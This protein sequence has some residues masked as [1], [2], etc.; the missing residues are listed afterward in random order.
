MAKTLV[1]SLDNISLKW[2]KDQ[3]YF[4]GGIA[5]IFKGIRFTTSKC[6]FGGKR[7]WF[8]CVCGSKV[9]NLYDSTQ[10]FR[11]RMCLNLAYKSQN[12]RK[13]IRNDV[14]LSVLDDFLEA[15]KL[16]EKT[17]RFTYAGKPT[18][19]QIKIELLYLKFFKVANM[20]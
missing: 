4:Y 14:M 17:R 3:G 2:L 7:F 11:C 13:R 15:Q 16:E 1:E 9:S 12:I 19:R 8:L 5:P 18:R 10:G 20:L 6:N